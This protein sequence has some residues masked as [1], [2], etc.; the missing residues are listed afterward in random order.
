M[1][2]AIQRKKRN[3]TLPYSKKT[4]SKKLPNSPTN[5]KHSAT[6]IEN[7]DREERTPEFQ[8]HFNGGPSSAS[9]A[10]LN[11]ENNHLEGKHRQVL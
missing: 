2:G 3:H 1:L 10:L 4:N 5:T 11:R 9:T 8:Q 7:G 6:Y